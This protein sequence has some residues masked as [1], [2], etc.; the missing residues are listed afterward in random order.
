MW[1]ERK[2]MLAE[3]TP[4]PSPV[5]HFTFAQC[6]KLNQNRDLPSAG[7]CGFINHQGRPLR[8]ITGNDPSPG[9]CESREHAG[10]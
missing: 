2:Q 6:F 9:L 3:L 8:E 10:S 5:N 1:R 7:S 4:T